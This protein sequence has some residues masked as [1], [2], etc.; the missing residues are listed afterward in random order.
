MEGGGSKA[1]GGKLNLSYS[2]LFFD[3]NRAGQQ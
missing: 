3:D 2:S 1:C